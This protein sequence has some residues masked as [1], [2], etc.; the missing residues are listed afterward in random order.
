MAKLLLYDNYNNRILTYTLNEDDAMPYSYGTTLKVREFRGSS[1]SPTLWTTIAT[2]EA[3]NLTRRSYGSGISVGYAFKRIWEGGHGTSSQHYAGVAFDV[4]QT[5]GSTARTAIYNAAVNSGAWGYVEPQSL[6]PTWVHFDRRLGPYACGG[7][8]G[9]PTLRRG[10]R[11]VYTLVLQDALSALGYPVG[12]T[13]DGIFG[14]K[15]ETALRGYQSRVGLSVD[16]VCGCNSWKKI[17]SAALD[18]GRTAT[19]ID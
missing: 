11:G 4:G 6:T 12:N 13:L 9:Y 10:A 19:V 18:I 16:G 7:T 14:S 3:W 2:M 1:D 17:T 5:Q 8:S 15:T